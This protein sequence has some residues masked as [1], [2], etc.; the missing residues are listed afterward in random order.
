MDFGPYF[1]FSKSEVGGGWG[2]GSQISDNMSADYRFFLRRHLPAVPFRCKGNW[3]NVP[4]MSSAG[5]QTPPHVELRVE[6][7]AGQ[8]LGYWGVARLRWGETSLYCHL[9]LN[10]AFSSYVT[11]ITW[12]HLTCHFT[13]H[14]RA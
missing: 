14:P 10:H 1:Y 12:E 9:H 6:S 8:T 3:V 5:C 4:D 7:W 2:G 13:W 11:F